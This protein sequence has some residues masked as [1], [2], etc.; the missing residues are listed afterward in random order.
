MECNSKELRIGNNVFTFHDELVRVNRAKKACRKQDMNLAILHDQQ[1]LEK[2]SDHIRECFLDETRRFKS[3][4]KGWHVAGLHKKKTSFSVGVKFTNQMMD[5]FVDGCQPRMNTLKDQEVILNPLKKKLSV[6]NKRENCGAV[7]NDAE[8]KKLFNYICMKVDLN[9]KHLNKDSTSVPEVIKPVPEPSPVHTTSSESPSTEK[10]EVTTTVPIATTVP[11]TTK[12]ITT[13]KV[14][15][16]TKPTTTTKVDTSTTQQTTDIPSTTPHDT[17]TEVTSK[18]N[19]PNRGTP[20]NNLPTI[21]LA[22]NTS[23]QEN[24]SNQ[25][26][27][28]ILPSYVIYGGGGLALVVILLVIVFVCRRIKRKRKQ[29][30][31]K[32]NVVGLDM[33]AYDKFKE[34]YMEKRHFDDDYDEFDDDEFDDVR[35]YTNY[36]VN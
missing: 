22:N 35:T 21:S 14:Q 28:G 1:T 20:T 26:N 24:V 16:T 7:G 5:L 31:K 11:T 3:T 10:T 30:P 4:T 6:V 34:S 18:T 12:S 32:K 27:D 9:D 15:T 2:V 25:S 33:G 36:G 17:P 23:N 8:V 29:N 13:N 19:F